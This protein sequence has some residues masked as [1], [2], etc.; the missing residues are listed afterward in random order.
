MEHPMTRKLRKWSKILINGFFSPSFFS[1]MFFRSPPI[2]SYQYYLTILE[3]HENL[4][5]PFYRG[6]KKLLNHIYIYIL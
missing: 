4:A 1:P 2:Y 5:C 3:V 6:F